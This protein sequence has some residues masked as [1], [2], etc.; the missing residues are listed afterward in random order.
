MS[1]DPPVMYW[2]TR[3]VG[4]HDPLL[5]VDGFINSKGVDPIFVLG[6]RE[7]GKKDGQP[8]MHF[9]LLF[10][11]PV[12]R[13]R[14]KRGVKLAFNIVKKQDFSTT[15]C[16]AGPGFYSYICKDNDYFNVHGTPP[17]DFHGLQYYK[18]Y[19]DNYR[20]AIV[21]AKK[22]S[23][24]RKLDM[25]KSVTNEF[26]NYKYDHNISIRY[27]MET[28]S[29]LLINYYENNCFTLPS[30]YQLNIE[31]R[32]LLLTCLNLGGEF[33]NNLVTDNLYLLDE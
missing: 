7:Y 10:D 1:K 25:Y 14:I 22:K 30:R 18:D 29:K 8:H 4:H 6:C 32:R 9:A 27:Q 21:D 23:A 26:N 11:T 20:K 5:I 12:S 2:W 17:L 15:A 16:S 33:A 31:Y 28:L 3:V 24:E 13:D 19:S